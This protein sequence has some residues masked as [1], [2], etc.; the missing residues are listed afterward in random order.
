MPN[1]PLGCVLFLLFISI[2]S[3]P[4]SAQVLNFPISGSKYN[5]A[6]SMDDIQTAQMDFNFM[7]INSQNPD[8]SPVQSPSGSISKLDLKAPWKAQHAFDRGYQL[9]QKKD[10]PG[11]VD[12]L[13]KATTI[14]PSYVAAHNALGTAYLDLKQNEQARDEFAKSV[15]LDDHLPNSY[16]NLGIAQLALKDNSGAEESLRKASSLAPLDLQ[17]STAMAY[18]EFVNHDYPAVL[19]T[20]HDVHGRKH[21]NAAVVHYFAA[22]AY[23]AQ[24]NLSD[25]QHEMETLLQ[26][27]PKSPSA[28]QFNEI[29]NQLK[30]QQKEIAEGKSRP[31]ELAKAQFTYSSDD[32]LKD[33]SGRAQKI[34]QDLKQKNEIAE[35]EAAPD[36]TCSDCSTIANAVP[37]VAHSKPAASLAGSSG[38]TFRATTDEVALFFAATDHGKS[39]TDLNAAD[40]AVLDDNRPPHAIL[41]FRNE[42]DL[43][44]RLGVVVDTSASITKRF[45]FEQAA[46]A[47]F[48]QSALTRPSDLAFLLEV[49]NSVLVVQDFTSDQAQMAHAI[50]QLAPGG[51]TALWDA[52][53]YAAEK[54]TKHPETQP[55]AR[56]V[57]VISDGEDNSSSTSLKEAIATAQRG[58]VAIY[59]V[60][61]RDDLLEGGS[62][63]GDHALETL[64]GL[65]G[66]AAFR[67]G[68]VSHFGKSLADLQQVLRGRY[69]V[70]YKPASFQRDGRYRTIDIKIKTEKEGHPIKVY[71]RKGYYASAAT[72]ASSAQ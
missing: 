62:E 36:A 67:P 3:G 49:N 43:P 10:L 47:K 50:D 38:S 33:S 7:Q 30:L 57:V 70:S 24:A 69:L 35:A 25:A 22:A 63:L 13:T 17:L 61:T 23:E 64:S 8:G 26:E 72:P 31:V 42:A 59:T 54:L 51:G 37:A 14:Y 19:E 18:G 65:S 34:L 39:V 40:V 29:L 12:Q 9:L 60:S 46:A 28:A 56:I 58:E 53:S 55:V 68:S 1:R 2:L 41:G 71:A 44:L 45:K 21:K 6:F 48:L 16:L 52:V 66:G 15:S 5:T 27:D 32:S 20:A 4:A 11:A